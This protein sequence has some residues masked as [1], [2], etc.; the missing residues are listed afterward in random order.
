M[1]LYEIIYNALFSKPQPVKSEKV[2]SKNVSN[3]L[4]LAIDGF[5]S[6]NAID[7]RNHRFFTHSIEDYTTQVGF[8]C[9][10][11]TDYNLISRPIDG[12]E[13]QIKL[14]VVLDL[15]R[16][17]VLVLTK[18]D[19]FEYDDGFIAVLND[20]E[21]KFVIDDDMDDEDASN[22]I[23]EEYWRVNDVAY[24]YTAKVKTLHDKN[25]DAKIDDSEVEESEVK[26]WDYSRITSKEGVNIEEFVYVEM[27]NKTGWFQIWRGAETDS[28][29]ISVF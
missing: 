8:Y 16:Q 3:P 23:H 12:E 9:H 20:K 2:A 5:V 29:N 21:K 13:L 14:R 11:M 25:E 24:S 27:N 15:D 6:I 28:A 26:F 10:R 4:N 7:L 19:E 18:F 22:D 1:K 17:R